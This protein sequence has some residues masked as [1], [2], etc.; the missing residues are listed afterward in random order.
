MLSRE[1]FFAV[2]PTLDS[3]AVEVP[4]LGGSMSVRVMTGLE[5]DRFEALVNAGS[6]GGKSP[7]FRALLIAFTACDADGNL[8]FAEGDI[9]AIAK[10][11]ST[12]LEPI[13][14]AALRLNKF[15]SPDIEGLE[16][17]SP[18]NPS[19]DSPSGSPPAS[20]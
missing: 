10:Y 5:R 17:N 12:T 3:E 1:A 16:K 15:T 11:P 9:P 18:S 19:D 4:A 14:N 7:S 2:K 6:K 20:A 8:L 13:A